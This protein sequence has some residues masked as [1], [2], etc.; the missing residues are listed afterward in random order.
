MEKSEATETR[1]PASSSAVTSRL[2][3][4]NIPKHYTEE[5]F[6]KHFQNE[7]EFVVT[8]IKIMRKGTKSRGFGFVG[9]KSEQHAK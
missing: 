7:G 5:R 6:K 1:P 4:K 3:I 8:D 9:F 2:I